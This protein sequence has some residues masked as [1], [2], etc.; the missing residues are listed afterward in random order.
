VIMLKSLLF[1]AALALQP[2]PQTEFVPASSL[3]PSEQLPSAPLLV[4]AY[5]FVWLAAMFYMW[6]IWKRLGKVDADIRTL[7]QRRTPGGGR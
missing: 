1:A 3:P 2:P 5:A 4:A 6:T 7:Q